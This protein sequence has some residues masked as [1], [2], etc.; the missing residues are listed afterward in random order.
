MQAILYL[1]QH[2]KNVGLLDR[3]LGKKAV[4]GEI[5][6]ITL[7][8]TQKICSG[9]VGKLNYEEI[10]E[11]CENIRESVDLALQALGELKKGQID[12]S[13]NRRLYYA[14]EQSRKHFILSIKKELQNIKLQD[15]Y[16]YY[17]IR[18]LDQSLLISLRDMAEGN[19]KHS[20]YLSLSFR[21]EMQNLG[22][23]INQLNKQRIELAKYLKPI[24]ERNQFCETVLNEIKNKE[25]LE[26]EIQK[27]EEHLEKL[28]KE[29][30][31]SQQ[32]LVKLKE[33][34]VVT[35]EKEEKELQQLEKERKDLD[36][37]IFSMVDV[38]S[39]VFRKYEKIGLFEKPVGIMINDY[40]EQPVK[41]AL[42][43]KE[44]VLTKIL[45]GVEK[46]IEKRE[47]KLKENINKKAL[48][49]IKRIRSGELKNLILRHEEV[50]KEIKEKQER[51][52]PLIKEAKKQESMLKN[53]VDGVEELSSR[54]KDLKQKI[55]LKKEESNKTK[56]SLKQ[57]V[58]ALPNH[59]VLKYT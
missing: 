22:R 52:E 24:I 40:L 34:T 11:T 35:Y 23:S 44:E 15:S 19:K 45:D 13:M 47:L 6:E 27:L 56:E 1:L 29:E 57:K 28:E 39:R 8:E 53:K 25:N 4:E 50:E 33:R 12:K 10:K 42:N 30:K 32:E 2:I 36:S 38:F 9:K 17:S 43:D 51:L 41:T 21:K 26:K 14:T 59:P 3:F 55:Q 7:E 20:Y 54:I 48:S 37:K 58:R 49:M 31:S 46:L 16:D 5:Q 18:E